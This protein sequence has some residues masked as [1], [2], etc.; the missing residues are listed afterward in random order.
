MDKNCS[1]SKLIIYMS[2]F[3]VK[4]IHKKEKFW[5]K[6]QIFDQLISFGPD[7]LI[8][9]S[10]EFLV[11]WNQQEKLNQSH[12]QMPLESREIYPT[13]SLSIMLYWPE[14]STICS[15]ILHTLLIFWIHAFY[16]FHIKLRF[17]F[18]HKSTIKNCKRP[19]K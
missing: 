8:N 6:F 13:P 7:G 19:L 3:L 15:S 9:N 16:A 5:T 4:L 17:N 11:F 1:L 18:I 12:Y 14:N 2:T 10:M